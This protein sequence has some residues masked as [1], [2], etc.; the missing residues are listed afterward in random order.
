MQEV[1]PTPGF[2][3]VIACLQRDPLP[4]TAFEVHLEPMQQE[5]MVKPTVATMCASC[6]VQDETM[7]ITYM[8]MVTTSVGQVAL[9]SFLPGGP[10]PWTHH[11]GHH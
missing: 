11:R 9:R 2:K 7:G 3:E 8:D 10:N 5:A 4:V 6:I 1:T